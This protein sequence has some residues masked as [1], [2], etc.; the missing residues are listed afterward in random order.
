M[1]IPSNP[2]RMRIE[3]GFAVHHKPILVMTMVKSHLQEPGAVWLTGHR[4]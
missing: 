2:V 3:Y 4:V 1:P